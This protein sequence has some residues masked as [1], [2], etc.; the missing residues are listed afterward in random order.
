MIASGLD[1]VEPGR[2]VESPYVDISE[3]Y[4]RPPI[5]RICVLV[6]R[7]TNYPSVMPFPTIFPTIPALVRSC[8]AQF[9]DKA[10]LI[11]DGR[12]LTYTDLER[13]SAHLANRLLAEGI[14]KGD[15][16]GILMPNS[17]EWA[18]AWFAITRIGAVAVP[19]NTFYK[20]SE[21]AWTARHADLR[22]I[23]AWSRFRNHDFLARLE[24]ALPGL[25][26]QATPG[27]SPYERAVLADRRGVGAIRSGVGHSASRWRGTRRFRHRRG[28]PR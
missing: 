21:L 4:G 19:L 15:H 10:F 1:P 16:V 24:E 27:A 26:R 5:M 22:A 14:G 11:A 18:L 6:F 23:L 7:E 8:A 9:G 28:F 13:R 17:V 2:I 12:E 3:F 20:G 25:A